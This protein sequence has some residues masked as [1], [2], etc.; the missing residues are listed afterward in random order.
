ML[1]HV[2]SCA[3]TVELGQW[4]FFATALH[5]EDGAAM[6]AVVLADDERELHA[7][8]TALERLG[9]LLLREH[10]DTHARQC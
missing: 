8:S 10:A 5:A 7:A 2:C 9:V 4:P 1:R 6:A 3:L